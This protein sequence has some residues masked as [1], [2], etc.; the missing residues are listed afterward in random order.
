[1]NSS[2]WNSQRLK[3]QRFKSSGFKRCSAVVRVFG[4]NKS[5]IVIIYII[6]KIF[7]SLKKKKKVENRFWLLWY[8]ISISDQNC[9]K[10]NKLFEKLYLPSTLTF[11]NFYTLYYKF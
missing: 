7:I 8:Q 9:F 11:S 4:S 6:Y 1:M 5:W 3:F 10:A 2:R